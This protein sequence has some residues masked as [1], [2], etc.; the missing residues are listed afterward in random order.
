MGRLDP[1]RGWQVADNL[2]E[3]IALILLPVAVLM[4]AYALTVFIWRS[5][6]ISKKTVR[7]GASR[8]LKLPRGHTPLG[9][10]VCCK[11]FQSV[12]LCLRVVLLALL[13]YG[14]PRTARESSLHG[15]AR[16]APG[17]RVIAMQTSA[18][19]LSARAGSSPLAALGRAICRG[20]PG[21]ASAC[22]H[23][24]LSGRPGLTCA[25]CA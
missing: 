18:R 19:L 11:C 20:R 3:V 21:H 22:R 4:C 25:S 13:T 14:Q 12:D 16:Q 23:P 2:V 24:F 10:L 7:L 5:R 8:A 9:A 6:A 17:H 1:E 15:Q